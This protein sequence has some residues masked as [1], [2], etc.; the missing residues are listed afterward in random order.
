[1]HPKAKSSF[2]EIKMVMHQKKLK[3]TDRNT[4]TQKFLNIYAPG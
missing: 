3:E 4:K 2:K 1:M